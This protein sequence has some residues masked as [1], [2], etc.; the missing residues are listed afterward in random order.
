MADQRS[1]EMHAFNSA[2]KTFAYMRLAE[3]LSRS[4][5]AFSSFMNEYLDPVVKADQRAQY[6]EEI[7]ISPNNGKVLTR[8]F[9]AVF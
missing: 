1:V 9:R 5:S 2:S 3:G 7:G 4:E 6:V 8:N